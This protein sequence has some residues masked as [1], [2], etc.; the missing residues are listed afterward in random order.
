MP[1]HTN[2]HIYIMHENLEIIRKKASIFSLY[3][4]NEE[5]E[6]LEVVC[7]KQNEFVDVASVR[8]QA[9]SL[10]CVHS[11]QARTLIVDCNVI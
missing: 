8:T 9:D 2:T 3:I 6:A 11:I 1:V 10:Q 7:S 4:I 5:T